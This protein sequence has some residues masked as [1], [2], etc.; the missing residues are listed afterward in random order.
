MSVTE[1]PKLDADSKR[2]A[3]MGY[4]QD[5]LEGLGLPY[6]LFGTNV[7]G[8]PDGRTTDAAGNTSGCSAGVPY[9]SP[10]ETTIT[11]GPSGYLQDLRFRFFLFIA[12]PSGG[13]TFECALD[14]AAFTACTSPFATASEAA[15]S[16]SWICSSASPPSWAYVRSTRRTWA[17]S[18]STTKSTARTCART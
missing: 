7:A 12:D 2:L 9:E 17:P 10:V 1:D 15:T 8:R 14:E 4:S 3:E 6:V 11:S 5:L 16:K 13:A 18:A